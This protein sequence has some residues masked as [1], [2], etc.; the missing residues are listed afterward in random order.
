MCDSLEEKFGAWELFEEVWER[1]VDTA[2]E[3]EVN[4]NSPNTLFEALKLFRDEI[5]TTH[6]T[7]CRLKL[8]LSTDGKDNVKADHARAMGNALFH[9]KVK[10]YIEAVKR[11][12]E[13]ISF[14]EKGSEARALAYANRSAVCYELHQYQECLDNIRLA[15]E[16]NYPARLVDKLNKR[17][18]SAK[19]ALEDVVRGK[20]NTGSSTPNVN[21]PN[22][23]S[24]SYEESLLV[25]H[26][27]NCL[28]LQT[29][30][31]FG[32]FVATTRDLKAGDVVI[33][34]KPYCT[35]LLDV[36]RL[37]RCDFCHQERLFNLIPCEGCTVAMYCSE[38]CMTQAYQRYHRYEC[39][40]IRDMW[41]IFTKIPVMAMRTV[42][43]A[44]ASFD[45]N[46]HDMKTHLQ[47]MDESKVDGFT[48]DW[49]KATPRDVY[50]TVHVLITNYEKRDPKDLAHRTFF[51]IIIYDLLVARSELGP[52]CSSDPD[53]SSLIMELLLKHLQTTPMNMHSQ[54][55]MDYQPEEKLYEIMNYASACFPLLSMINHSCAPN[56]TRVTLH[57]GRCAAVISRPISKGGQLYD[58]Y[59]QHHSLMPVR[60]RRAK[61]LTQYKFLCN[62]EACVNNY[63]LYNELPS[64][65][66]LRYGLIDAGD[67]HAQLVLH[68]PKIAA[69]LLPKLTQ[70]LNNIGHQYPRFEVS[71]CQELFL[72]SF[73]ILF[74]E[75]SN[76]AQYWKYC[77][78]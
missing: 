41:R 62:C 27:V 1:V 9:P 66:D 29:S 34:E 19:N 5:T 2:T 60:E 51:A 49:T 13:S 28:E 15:R 72:R 21:A 78:P 55:Y 33:I 76:S 61:L 11:Y 52:E 75:T 68:Q 31:E 44:I 18:K 67:I 74:M 14:S 35:L 71:S 47:D 3:K 40:V 70:Y 73:Q 56:L 54:Y 45:H 4:K 50:D 16:S 17:E 39:P 12:N 25:P 57:D 64:I 53:I 8:K 10:R 7:E 24:L 36:Y 22:K 30:D 69:E 65:S 38:E 20:K 58:N 26:A 48:M 59:G 43:T 6:L 63:P 42:T 77:N 23:L 37:I 32:R 46:L